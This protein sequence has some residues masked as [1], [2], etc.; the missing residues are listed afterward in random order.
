MPITLDWLDVKE[1][2]IIYHFTDTWTLHDAKEAL[3]TA[4]YMQDE[5]SVQHVSYIYDLTASK[6][7]P[8]QMMQAMKSVISLLLEPAPDCIIIVEPSER[9]RMVIDTL[10]Q[11]VPHKL[12][13][14]IFYAQTLP[15]AQTLL[16][17]YH[18]N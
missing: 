16:K 8:R 17:Q 3:Q 9:I 12:H 15:H 6:V 7:P 10:R 14:R 5:Q 4:I 1:Q 11:V 18:A 2:A 13:E